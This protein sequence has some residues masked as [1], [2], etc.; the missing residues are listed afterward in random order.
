MHMEEA[1]LEKTLTRLIEKVDHKYYGKYR[2]VVVANN[3]PEKLGRLK[4]KAPSVLVCGSNLKQVIWNI[5][6][7]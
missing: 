6:S 2:G 1:L 4:V 7:G 3:D 5:P